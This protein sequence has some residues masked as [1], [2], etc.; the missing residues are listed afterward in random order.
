MVRNYIL[1]ILA[2]VALAAVSGIAQSQTLVLNDAGGPP[3][4]TTDGNGFLD[5]IAGKAFKEVGLTMKLIRTPPERALLN[6][7]A[8]IDDGELV[9]IK[10]INNTYTNLVRVP[11][12]LIDWTFVAL[13]RNPDIV[14]R[15]WNDLRKYN[16]GFIRGW[17]ILENNTKRHQKVSIVRSP[18]E[19]FAMLDKDRI[20]IA[21]YAKWMGLEIIK[22]N[23]IQGV[24]VLEPPLAM[25]EMYIYLNKKHS[26]YVN[27]I[28]NALKKMKESG[29]YKKLFDQKIIQPY[30]K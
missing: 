8:G 13:T 2:C 14:V 19:L 15:D 16:I 6:A 28:A 10:G 30:K 25:R 21:L 5:I 11:E 12:K 3:F 7:N 4:T 17:K 20:D 27:N 23:N 24:R 1:I 26:A 18:K 9:R 29:E 22:K